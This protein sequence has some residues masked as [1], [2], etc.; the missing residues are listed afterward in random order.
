M[1]SLRRLV[2]YRGGNPLFLDVDLVI[3]DGQKIGITGA[4]GCGKSSFFSLLKNE[5]HQDS[6]DLHMPD[7]AVIAHVEQEVEASRRQAIEYVIDG[8]TELR[9]LEREMGSNPEG[10]KLAHLLSRFEEIGGYGASS[11][12][13]RLMHGLGFGDE[14]ISRPVQEFS[15]GWRMRLNLAKAL[16]CRSDILLLDEPTN[17]LDLEAVLWLESWLRDYEGTLLLISHDRDFLDGTVDFICHIEEKR[18]TLY[19]GNYGDFERQRAANLAQ[20]QALFERQ[21]RK[22]AHLQSYIDRFRAKAT[23]ARQAQSR[24]R[25]LERM[26]AVSAAH[27]DSPFSFCFEAPLPASN[28]LLKLEKAEAGYASKPVLRNVDLS[29]ESGSRIGLIGA[30]GAGKSTLVKLIAGEIEPLSGQRIEGK[31]LKIGYFAQHQ[32]ESLRSEETP[33][34]HVQRLNREAREQDIRDYLGGFGFAGDKVFSPVGIFSGG[35]K[36]RLSLALIIRG[37]PNLLLLDEPTNHLDLE[38]RHALTFALQDYD[39]AILIVSHDRHLVRTVT[40]SLILVENGSAIA[41]EGDMEDYGRR[42]LQSPVE[43]KPEKENKK[44]IEAEAR[45]RRRPLRLK[46][47]KLEEEMER[48]NGQKKEIEESIADPG[49][50]EDREAVKSAVLRQARIESKLSEV[51]NNWLELQSELEALE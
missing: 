17:H 18:L 15:G 12:A 2:F 24:I 43:K 16:M 23:K 46:I 14:Q 6:G 51:E 40:D 21:Q 4:N 11:R 39:G 7:R 13:A 22:I 47:A 49:F 1:I 35:E 31:G 27:V 3:H 37:R 25:A 50:Y 20:Q 30:N 34:Q 36:A 44:R 29:I 19:T 9:D 42:V 38:M 8:D 45:A 48:L 32:L 10:G 33:F 26:E 5:L 41:F 28:P